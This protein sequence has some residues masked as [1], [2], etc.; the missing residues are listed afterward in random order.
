M[1][2]RRTLISAEVWAAETAELRDVVQ[3]S[4]TIRMEFSSF[5]DY[6]NPRLGGQGTVG[7][8]VTSLDDEKCTLLENHVRRA[9]LAGATEGPRSFAATA[10]AV[11]GIV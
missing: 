10:W 9:Y 7:A 5:A 6:W 4:L 3:T 8:Y 11:R 2:W 1:K